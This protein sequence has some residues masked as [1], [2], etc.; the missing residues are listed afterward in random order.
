VSKEFHRWALL[1]EIGHGVVDE[2]HWVSKRIPARTKGLRR[3]IYLIGESLGSCWN[4]SRKRKNSHVQ[5]LLL[6]SLR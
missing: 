6:C 4:I 2:E 1:G 3:A 5:W